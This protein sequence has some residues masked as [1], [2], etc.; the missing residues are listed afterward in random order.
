MSIGFVHLSGTIITGIL[1]FLDSNS[2]RL[3]REVCKSTKELIDSSA[4]KTVVACLDINSIEEDDKIEIRFFFKQNLSTHYFLW[5]CQ[6]QSIDRKREIY[7]RFADTDKILTA[8]MN[9]MELKGYLTFLKSLAA[10]A[11]IHE[12]M[13]YYCP[14]AIIDM[15]LFFLE[16]TIISKM[17]ICPRTSQTADLVPLLQIVK[18]VKSKCV[19]VSVMYLTDDMIKFVLQLA[20]IVESIW[21]FHEACQLEPH[22][23]IAPFAREIL[24]RK[25]EKVEISDNCPRF[26]L[27]DI[28][29]LVQFL[30]KKDK[31]FSFVSWRSGSGP[32]NAQ[33][34]NYEVS[35]IGSRFRICHLEMI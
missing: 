7:L 9:P 10:Q 31:K 29:Q 13:I 11:E 34:G 14:P 3:L 26:V 20:D 27:S 24:N 4:P 17:F 1:K 15:L 35:L 25:C 8:S 21:F 12:L 33:I 28:E 22:P 2:R 16:R 32:I 19:D 23:N 30:H 18:Q 5:K 6:M